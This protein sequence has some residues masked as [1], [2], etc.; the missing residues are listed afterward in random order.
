MFTA[1]RRATLLF[2]SPS[3]RD[4]NGKH[5]F[6]V[7][8]DPCGP[9]NQVLMVSVATLRDKGC[10]TTC[11]LK[12][13]DHEFIKV[14][15]YIAYSFCRLEWADKLITAVN[16]G[17]LVDKGL[18]DERIFDR[19]LTGLRKSPSTK[20]FAVQFLDDCTRRKK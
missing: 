3:A 16:N 9:A 8:T 10:D 1:A 17:A 14:D 12:P 18:L 19:V 15:S 13:G 11:L 20:P 7:L 2:P 4:E 5:L 6:I